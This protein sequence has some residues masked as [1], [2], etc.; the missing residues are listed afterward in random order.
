MINCSRAA[1][2]LLFAPLIAPAQQQ[3]Q[4]PFPLKIDA[5]HN[6]AHVLQNKKMPGFSLYLQDERTVWTVQMSDTFTVKTPV[7]LI[8]PK[9]VDNSVHFLGGIHRTDSALLFYSNRKRTKLN[10]TV[11]DYRTGA[12]GSQLLEVPL[13]K[14]EK[15]WC[16]YTLANK[17]YLITKNKRDSVLSIATVSHTLVVKKRRYFVGKTFLFTPPQQADDYLINSARK[18]RTAVAILPNAVHKT[19][20]TFSS[21]KLYPQPDALWLTSDQEPAY[22]ALV[23]IDLM[24]GEVSEQTFPQPSVAQ[25]VKT[26]SFVC[27]NKLFQARASRQLLKFTATD[28]NSQEVLQSYQLM[29]R[30]PLTFGESLVYQHGIP[31]EK[32]Q[33]LFRDL[34]GVGVNNAQLAIAVN[35]EYDNYW[36][37]IGAYT[38]TDIIY[39]YTT[40]I[41]TL[42]L[43]ASAWGLSGFPVPFARG[44][45]TIN[46]YLYGSLNAKTLSSVPGTYIQTVSGKI[47]RFR[48]LMNAR[49][50]RIDVEVVSRWQDHYLH[51][52]YDRQL[53]QYMINAY[54]I[55]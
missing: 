36:C 45:H 25:G 24:S 53:E 43:Q 1:F 34:F 14:H 26:N 30:E 51:G 9:T 44:N 21:V 55:K 5:Y 49:T 22:T 12:V 15:P 39:Y 4:L 37:Q 28:I 32:T 50:N 19:E 11:I 31:T 48:K 27:N 42:P 3:L 52:F 54:P 46:T 13:E 47:E 41:S 16:Y 6:A 29:R 40:P 35:L 10:V 38:S 33:A 7:K 8:N 2:V 20:H 17:L 18:H 23:R